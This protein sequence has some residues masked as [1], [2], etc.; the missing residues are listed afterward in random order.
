MLQLRLDW[1]WKLESVLHCGSGESRP[2]VA[3]RLVQRDADGRPSIAGDAVRGVL[4]MS[5]EQVAGWLGCSQKALYQDKESAPWEPGAVPLA[6]LFGRGRSHVSPATVPLNARISNK[7]VAA[8][9]I[10]AASGTAEDETLRNTEVVG[11][12]IRLRAWCAVSVPEEHAD[13]V[14]TLLLASVAASEQIAAKAG[15][16]WG[17]LS[18]ESVQLQH[19]QCVMSTPLDA[20][21]PDR[22]TKL[23]EALSVQMPAEKDPERISPVDEGKSCW[24]EIDLELNEP[25]CL[26]SHLEISNHVATEQAPSATTI[27]GALQR[28]WR[29]RGVSDEHIAA[30]LSQRTQWSPAFPV[31]DGSMFGP[32]PLSFAVPKGLADIGKGEYLVDSLSGE[33][34]PKGPDGR[35]LSTRPPGAPWIAN[36]GAGLVTFSAARET[37]M[38]IARD[39]WSGSKRGGA[40]YSRETLVASGAIFRAWASLPVSAFDATECGEV[41][42]GK[43]P[44]AGNGRATIRV[45][46]LTH[47]PDAFC[48]PAPSGSLDLFIELLSPAIVLDEDGHPKR[49]LTADDWAEFGKTGTL[50]GD[51][52]WRVATARRGGWMRNW[53]HPRAAVTAIKPGSVWRLHCQSPAEAEEMRIAL[54]AHRQIGIRQHEGFGWFA[55]DPPWIRGKPPAS[56][57]VPVDIARPSPTTLPSVWPG[58]EG[59]GR[60]V[61][62]GILRSVQQHVAGLDRTAREKLQAPLQE[63]AERARAVNTPADCAQVAVFWRQRTQ[64]RPNG[65][66]HPRWE[67]AKKLEPLLDPYWGTNAHGTG[68]PLL[69]RF[70]LDTLLVLTSA[71]KEES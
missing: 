68:N 53:H 21:K 49:G 40:L 5:A 10:D 7:V 11:G 36:N 56:Q 12:D 41:F 71:N 58:T 52:E 50:A 26:P 29:N 63:L 32:M 2:G 6:L 4:R 44:S 17:R 25:A 62:L 8:T 13:A 45:R 1:T 69:L 18:V 39:Y 60:G 48:G 31:R 59:A 16:G 61:L 3:D 20:V 35:A 64:P 34:G 38:H 67:T 30:F 27:R 42:L 28:H 70:T 46:R 19:N 47:P 55:V 22:L 57:T 54:A 65:R 24:F 66:I 33:R 9:A 51:S 14:E 43:R 23:K 15:I 37:R